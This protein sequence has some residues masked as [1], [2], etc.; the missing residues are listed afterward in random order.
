MRLYLADINKINLERTGE[1]SPERAAQAENF[2]KDDDKKRCIAGGLFFKRFLGDAEIKTNKYGKPISENGLW[3]NLSH[4][5]EYVLFA[6]SDN[7][8]GCDIE[9]IRHISA[10]HTGKIIF[11]DNEMNML[12]N[13][14][15]KTGVF[16]DLWTKKESLLKCIGEGFHRSGKSVD[17]SGNIFSENG[18]EYYFRTWHFSDYT[19][20]VCSTDKEFPLCIEFIVL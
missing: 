16:F 7:E 14:A 12:K 2:R 1:I 9:Q 6:L 11:S 17:V 19:I 4:S 8:V 10:E 15:D 13:S 5:G 18:K 3:F 20:T